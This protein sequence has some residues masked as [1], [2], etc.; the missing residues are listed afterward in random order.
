LNLNRQ[1][2]WRCV[3]RSVSTTRRQWH[4]ELA[5][6]HPGPSLFHIR[7]LVRVWRRRGVVAARSGI[8]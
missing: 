2:T 5:A 8:D 4:S 7:I 1:R 3:D 6:M